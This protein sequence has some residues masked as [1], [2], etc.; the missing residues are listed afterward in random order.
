[1][2]VG[3]LI[4]SHICSYKYCFTNICVYEFYVIVHWAG[5]GGSDIPITIDIPSI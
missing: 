3:V 1:M 2:C 4:F 5:L